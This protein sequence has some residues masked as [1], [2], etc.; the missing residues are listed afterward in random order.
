MKK[1]NLFRDMM[2]A[3]FEL[4]KKIKELRI[5]FPIELQAVTCEMD[6]HDY[7]HMAVAL[8]DLRGIK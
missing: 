3:E 1:P 2:H 5:D 8:D 7:V 6:D 4:G